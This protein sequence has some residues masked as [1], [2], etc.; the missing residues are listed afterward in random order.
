MLKSTCAVGMKMVCQG[1]V[2]FLVEDKIYP[3][4]HYNNFTDSET[5]TQVKQSCDNQQEVGVSTHPVNLV[6]RLSPFSLHSEH[7]RMLM[8]A[9]FFSLFFFCNSITAATNLD[10]TGADSSFYIP[11]RFLINT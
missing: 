9:F 3:Q 8:C 11:F 5:F 7:V 1:F 10:S 2:S 6:K 4:Q